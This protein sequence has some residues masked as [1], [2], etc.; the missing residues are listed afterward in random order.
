MDRRPCIL[1]DEIVKNNKRRRPL[2]M[3]SIT[4]ILGGAQILLGVSFNIQDVFEE[5]LTESH[6]AFLAMLR[7]IEEH[8]PAVEK[9]YKGR[10]RT[11]LAN[12]PII[13]AFLAKSFFNI[14]TTSGLLQRLNSDSSLRRICGSTYWKWQVVLTT[15]L[16]NN[17]DHP[18]AQS[19]LPC[20]R[21]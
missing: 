14:D 7:V 12:Q 8:L 17:F 3:K 20:L 6:R 1:Y 18:R 4:E 16:E 11:P 5:Y 21:I 13:R 19:A 2:P 15:F 10:G 9:T